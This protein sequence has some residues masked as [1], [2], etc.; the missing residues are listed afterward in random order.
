MMRRTIAGRLG[1]GLLL[2]SLGAG[3]ETRAEDATGLLAGRVLSVTDGDTLRVDLTSGPIV[4]RLSGID[5]PERRQPWGPEAQQALT[6]RARDQAVLLEVVSQDRYDRLVATVYLEN[7]EVPES[8]LNTWLVAEGHAWAYRQ[9][10][11]D[12]SLCHFEDEAR[13]NGL[14]LWK[15]SG[16]R[17]VAPWEWRMSEAGR[18]RTLTDF[19]EETAANCIRS[20]REARRRAEARARAA[21][22]ESDT[23]GGSAMSGEPV[24]AE[25]ACLREAERQSLRLMGQRPARA[26][27]GGYHVVLSVRGTDGEIRE[28]DCRFWVNTGRAQLGP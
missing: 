6:R 24:V 1:I 25:R 8:S 3:G 4:V 10:A 15:R 16:A 19:S 17:P 18:L 21:Q 2:V 7:D 23:A 11:V 13:R 28:V 20:I 27:A 22:V 12:E 9:F 14:G 5:A 26:I